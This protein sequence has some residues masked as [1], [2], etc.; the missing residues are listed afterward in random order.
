MPVLQKIR[1]IL[2]SI[3]NIW[4]Y[5]LDLETVL[6]L[7]LND[8]KCI[9]LMLNTTL[10]PFQ[11]ISQNYLSERFSLINKRFALQLLKMA[12]IILLGQVPSCNGVE[13]SC[14]GGLWLG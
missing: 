9:T 11:S 5:Y 3:S 13:M 4:K 12:L 10:N 8:T 6:K 1:N 2:Q 14:N 7:F